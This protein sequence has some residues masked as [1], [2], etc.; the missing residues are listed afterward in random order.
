AMWVILLIFFFSSRRRHTRF[1]REWSSDVCSSDLTDPRLAALEQTLPD[2][3]LLTDAADLEPYGRDWT[4]RW[5]PAPL[6]IALPTTVEQ[7][8]EE[9]RVGKARRARGSRHNKTRNAKTRR[10]DESV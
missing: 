10:V 6:A 8:S 2:L 3:R 1:S 7:R 9:R 5:T 4:R